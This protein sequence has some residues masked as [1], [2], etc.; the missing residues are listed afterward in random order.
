[1][2]LESEILAVDKE[3]KDE[4]ERAKA[5]AKVK[6]KKLRE[7]AKKK[8]FSNGQI[9]E[10]ELKK[11]GV[12]IEKPFYAFSSEEVVELAEKLAPRLAENFAEESEDE[13]FELEYDS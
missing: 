7:K 8:F 1:M 11:R 4:V 9:L 12:K 6:R 5:K 10:R 13:D 2:T 3:L